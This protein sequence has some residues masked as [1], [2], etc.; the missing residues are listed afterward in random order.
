MRITNQHFANVG[1]QKVVQPSGTR[2]FFKGQQ[3][4]AQATNKLKNR[5]GFRFENAFH[6]QISARISNRHGDRCLMHIHPNYL[7]SFMRVLLVVD[8]DANDQN[9]LQAG[10]LL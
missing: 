6:H 10:A 1:F 7:A 9:L 3:T 4:A 2:S 8:V 5:L